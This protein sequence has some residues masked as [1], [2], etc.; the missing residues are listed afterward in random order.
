MQAGYVGFYW[1]LPV[2]WARF[3]RLPRDVDAAAAR[4]RTICYQR[5]CVQRYVAE[6]R[7]RLVGE[8]PFM[9]VRPDRGTGAVAE[10]LGRAKELCVTADAT[11]LFVDFTIDQLRWRPHK[12]L[13][14]CLQTMGI[15][16][17]PVPPYPLPIDRDPNFDIVKHF[18]TWKLRDGERE[19]RRQAALS[20]LIAAVARAPEDARDRWARVARDLNA[21]GSFTANGRVW[22]AAN[23]YAQFRT[24]GLAE[25]ARLSRRGWEQG[26]A[27]PGAL[28][29]TQLA[30]P[31]SA[32]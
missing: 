32:P 4:S 26:V 2:K 28:A 16:H 23:V 11:L 27:Q 22:S 5:A 13:R 6:H 30:M 12:P 7:G 14:D 8:L 29:R 3:Y 25:L 1:T 21:R 31:S 17:E 18:A 20:E 19:E 9:D 15:Q 24:H 10:A